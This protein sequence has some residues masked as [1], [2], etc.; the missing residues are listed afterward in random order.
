MT[1]RLIA[2]LVLLSGAA[3]AHGLCPGAVGE[4]VTAG[5]DAMF[6]TRVAEEL[7]CR[8]TEDFD[9][10]PVIARLGAIDNRILTN[11][12]LQ[13]SIATGEPIEITRCRFTTEVDL[14]G[15]VKQQIVFRQCEFEGNVNI[16]VAQTAGIEFTECLFHQNVS[17]VGSTVTGPLT[18]ANSV[19]TSQL[20]IERSALASGI[21]ATT[22]RFAKSLTVR[23]VSTSAG[24]L[25]EG[26]RFVES[27]DVVELES[28]AG[29][30]FKDCGFDSTS[31]ISI[32]GGNIASGL[33]FDSCTFANRW[34]GAKDKSPAHLK[35]SDVTLGAALVIGRTEPDAFPTIGVSRSVIPFLKVPEWRIIHANLLAGAARLEDERQMEDA[36]ELLQLIRRGYEADGR[37]RD[38]ESVRRHYELLIARIRGGPTLWIRTAVAYF[39]WALTLVMVILFSVASTLATNAKSWNLIDQ[40]RPAWRLMPWA[41]G[42]AA[43]AFLGAVPD[44]VAKSSAPTGLWMFRIT[45]VLGVLISFLF[46]IVVNEWVHV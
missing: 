38:A 22:T 10:S 13:Q 24:F 20:M 39:G 33:R 30:R 34:R 23:D 37:R 40:N 46:G 26:C 3:M 9:S 11:A 7:P 1:S 25:F 41:I 28:A 5:N 36:A 12:E 42:L 27:V 19:L 6:E 21:R 14:I 44:N 15:E 16:Q 17:V 43:S 2:M 8:A 32:D 29:I 35:M 4:W 18:F 45:R 31:L